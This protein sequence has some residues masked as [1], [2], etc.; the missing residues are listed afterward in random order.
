MAK[1]ER[2]GSFV[3]EDLVLARDANGN[4]SLID[5][6]GYICCGEKDEGDLVILDKGDVVAMLATEL[7]VSAFDEVKDFAIEATL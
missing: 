7:D 4:I 6:V 5:N 3:L 2:F 1:L